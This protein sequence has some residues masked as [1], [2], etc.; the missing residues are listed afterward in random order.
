MLEAA[1]QRIDD[2]GHP[3]RI[4]SRATI[5]DSLVFN[6]RCKLCGDP[7]ANRI[8]LKGNVT[9][10]CDDCVKGITSHLPEFTS[11]KQFDYAYQALASHFAGIPMDRLVSTSRQFPGHMRAD[12]QAGIDRLFSDISAAVFRHL[13]RASLRDAELRGADPGWPECARDRAGAVSRRGC[14]RE[15]AGEMSRQRPVAL[16]DRRRSALRRGAL[17]AS[18]V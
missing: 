15:R 9:L 12:V 6:D 5:A 4:T 10:V 16:P 13:R 18:R 2:A 3:L 14:R 7:F 17:L 1:R 11:G 8:S